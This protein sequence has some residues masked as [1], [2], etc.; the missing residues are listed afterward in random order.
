MIRQ[1]VRF[2]SDIS[3]PDV[4]LGFSHSLGHEDAFLRLRLS[5]RYRFSE[6]TLAGTQGNGRDAPIAAAPP[7][8][9]TT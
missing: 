9:C 3:E 5:A 1:A 7:D 6:G 8:F 2:D 4:A